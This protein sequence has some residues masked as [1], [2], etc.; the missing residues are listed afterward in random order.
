MD[1]F[2]LLRYRQSTR[3]FTE[4]QISQNDLSDILAAANST[5]VGSNLYK[6]IHL[7]VVQSRDVLNKLSKAA[8]KRWEDKAKIKKIVGDTPDVDLSQKAFDPFYGAQTVIFVSHRKQDLQPGIEF[9]NAACI[10]Y[11]MHLAAANLGL[12]SVFM[13]YALES[14]R[15]IPELDN[16]AVLSLP[17]DFEPLI[18]IAIGH[19]ATKLSARDLKTGKIS[20]NY[21]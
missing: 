13:W 3:K 12:G 21:L 2:E 4:E 15:E 1:Y 6:D 14:M 9:S 8:V 19:P 17:D 10:T 18:G 11:S 16:T 20:I 5:P 7:T